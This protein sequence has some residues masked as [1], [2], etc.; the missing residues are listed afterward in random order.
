MAAT[1]RT[2]RTERTTK[3]SNRALGRAFVATDNTRKRKR[4]WHE[5][6]A[7]ATAETRR[8][9]QNLAPPPEHWKNLRGHS[10]EAE[11]KQA[12]QVE[13]NEIEN[14]ETYELIETTAV[15]SGKQIL[16]TRWVFTHKLNLAGFL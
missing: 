15:P 13:I 12:A 2:T 1:A 10:D 5:F 9:R 16:P 11:F 4:P 6:Q 8:S 3:P 7:F 14:K